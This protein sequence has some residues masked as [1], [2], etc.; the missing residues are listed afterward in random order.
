MPVTNRKSSK[1]YRDTIPDIK[2]YKTSRAGCLSPLSTIRTKLEATK[3]ENETF[4]NSLNVNMLKIKQ[5][6][7]T[8]H[9]SSL[10]FVENEKAKL[11]ETER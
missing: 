8:N 3:K 6:G 10:S 9:K 2:G 7:K 4:N 11:Y 5:I 1:H